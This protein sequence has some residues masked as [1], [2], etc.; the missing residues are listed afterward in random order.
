MSAKFFSRSLASFALV[1]NPNISHP[2]TSKVMVVNK[3]GDLELYAIYDTPKQPIWSSRGEL[4]IGAG[5]GLKF[6]EGYQ[7]PTLVDSF[8][9]ESVDQT[10]SIF[11]YSN[12]DT[13][14]RS[15]SSRS[16][17]MR[18]HSR[19]RGRSGQRPGHLELPNAGV[20]NSS[21]PMAP[22]GLLAM[23]LAKGRTYSPASAKKYKRSPSRT[24]TISAEDPSGKASSRRTT[25]SRE[26]NLGFLHVLQDDISMIMRRRA[27]AGYGLS[28]V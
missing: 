2:L 26:K 28:K 15:R 19:A 5:V 24:D 4:A 18:E 10:R 6:I 12:M 7:I 25:K 27:L 8:S 21:L 13:V 23:K 3:D 17:P 16:V 22:V 11:K 20:G 9:P 14:S 1:P